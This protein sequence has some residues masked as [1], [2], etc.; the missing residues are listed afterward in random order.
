M[1]LVMLHY[2]V[3]L[4]DDDSPDLKPYLDNNTKGASWKGSAKSWT[5]TDIKVDDE[6]APNPFNGKMQTR[7]TLVLDDGTPPPPPPPEQPIV[8]T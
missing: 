1:V 5:V 7:V 2:I 8:T 6:F 4:F 3:T